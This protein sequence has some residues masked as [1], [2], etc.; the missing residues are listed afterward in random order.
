[1]I[2]S[3][4]LK[5]FRHIS[6]HEPRPLPSIRTTRQTQNRL[7]SAMMNVFHNGIR[8]HW[9]FRGHMTFSNKT[10]SRQRSLILWA[11]KIHCKIYHGAKLTGPCEQRFLSC[12]SLASWLT[13]SVY[14]VI[15]EVCLSRTNQLR[16]WQATR[17]TSLTLKAMQERNLCS[18]GIVLRQFVCFLR[19]SSKWDLTGTERT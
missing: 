9:L 18:R 10:F 19:T 4:K 12:N 7:G 2:T 3:A 5:R 14:G 1:M 17:T 11:G 8:S 16:D 6:E 15:R 13:S